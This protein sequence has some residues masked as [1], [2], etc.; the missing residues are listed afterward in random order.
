MHR[1]FELN[2]V[3][4]YK[5]KTLFKKDQTGFDCHSHNQ[6]AINTPYY[7][8]GASAGNELDNNFDKGQ[9]IY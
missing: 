4:I 7:I 8:Y 3:S 9:K 6:L 1:I 5:L 2:N